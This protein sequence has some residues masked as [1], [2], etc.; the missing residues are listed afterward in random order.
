MNRNWDDANGRLGGLDMSKQSVEES[1]RK[2]L[3]LSK[4]S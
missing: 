4:K 1:R 2:L 3:V